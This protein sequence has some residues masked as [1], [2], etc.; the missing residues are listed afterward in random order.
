[1]QIWVFSG[2]VSPISRF[3]SGGFMASGLTVLRRFRASQVH[4]TPD[5]STE[6][7]TL[8]RAEGACL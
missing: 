1:M 8:Q 4:I 2:E 3:A 7:S 6:A 5:E